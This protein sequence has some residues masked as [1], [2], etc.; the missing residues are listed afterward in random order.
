MSMR[1]YG[2]SNQAHTM[3]LHSVYRQVVYNMSSSLNSGYY[4]IGMPHQS[5]LHHSN[6]IPHHFVCQLLSILA[7]S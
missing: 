2:L 1:Y 7:K 4:D 6:E 3:D 5:K